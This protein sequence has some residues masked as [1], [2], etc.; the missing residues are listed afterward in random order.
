MFRDNSGGTRKNIDDKIVELQ[1]VATALAE[2]ND[3]KDA[4]IEEL[5]QKIAS[6]EGGTTK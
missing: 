2:A 4:K 5:Q 3:E 6:L 1:E